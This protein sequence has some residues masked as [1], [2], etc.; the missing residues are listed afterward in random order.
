MAR[1]T[2]KQIEELRQ[3]WQYP[4]A[5]V[6]LAGYLKRRPKSKGALELFVKTFVDLQD[7]KGAYEILD[8]LTTLYPNDGEYWGEKTCCAAVMENI[9]Y[10]IEST[11]D[12]KKIAEN[13]KEISPEDEYDNYFNISLETLIDNKY[14]DQAKELVD[15]LLVF[16]FQNNMARSI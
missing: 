1:T 16:R 11:L 2:L 15:A 14:Y 10:T 12:Y 6:E 9:E 7:L 8:I 13:G 3:K 4:E 5:L